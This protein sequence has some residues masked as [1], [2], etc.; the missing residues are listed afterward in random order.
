MQNLIAIT[1][2]V[3]PAIA[4]CELTHISRQAIDVEK[5]RR[6]H[7]AYEQCL[8]GL[9]CTLVRLPA[10]PRLPDSVFVEDTAVVLDEV[11]LA[12]RPGARSRR[13]ETKSV[14]EAL[15]AYRRVFHIHAP[16][17][18]D[19]GDVLVVGSRVFV[20]MSR[21]TNQAGL[22]EVRSLLTPL[23]YRVEGV[24]VVSALHLKSAVTQVAERALLVNHNWT[25]TSAFAGADSGFELIDVAPEEPFG[26]N[27]LLIGETV[28]YPEAYPLTRRRLED[29][30]ITVVA[31]DISELAKAEGG[32]TCSSLVFRANH[33]D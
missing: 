7:L 3:S 18:L 9:G 1:R 20:G 15:A 22:E 32:V 12:A 11:A 29:R 30:E 2:E 5:A 31:V 27:A 14:A 33:S 4:R 28:V 16:C 26:A 10:D 23:G 24:P 8:A 6:Q 13:A 21:R 17:T 25:D 19:G